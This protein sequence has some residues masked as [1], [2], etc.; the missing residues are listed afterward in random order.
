M[1]SLIVLSSLTPT[2]VKLSHKVIEV[3]SKIPV[4]LRSARME[5][6]LIIQ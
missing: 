3:T 1:Q 5:G 2:P 4:I 6:A